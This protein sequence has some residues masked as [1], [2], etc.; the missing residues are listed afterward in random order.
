MNVIDS[1]I[2]GVALISVLIVVVIITKSFK[3][4]DKDIIQDIQNNSLG[5]EKKFMTKMKQLGI[6]FFEWFIRGLRQGIQKIHFWAIREKKKSKSDI[7]KAKDELV[8]V[9]DKSITPKKVGVKVGRKKKQQSNEILNEGS[10]LEKLSLQE[11]D[12]VM[13]SVT[14]GDD[15]SKNV[16][17]SSF[18]KGLFKGKI[19]KKKNV[20]IKRK[21]D[22]SP[23]EWSLGSISNVQEGKSS[24]SLNKKKQHADIA[25]DDILGVDRKILE[26]KILQKID[27]DPINI[28]NYHELG[29]LYIK[30]KKYDDANEVFG[31][32][33]GVAPNDLEAKRR[34]DKIKLLKKAELS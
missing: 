10:I 3:R 4:V 28:N 12:T 22:N 14:Q 5:K 21:N 17:K 27:K 9:H 34:Q 20:D 26:K 13:D 24:E 19:I 16:G 31:Y 1:V 11:D 33:L 29:A 18:I 25:E 7:A 6:S 30:M 8:I 32:I 2:I 15:G 23:E